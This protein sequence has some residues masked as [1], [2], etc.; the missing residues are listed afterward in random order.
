MI[1]DNFYR[2]CF[3]KTN[4]NCTLLNA[5]WVVSTDQ[6]YTSYILILS[7]IQHYHIKSTNEYYKKLIAKSYMIELIPLILYYFINIFIKSVHCMAVSRRSSDDK[8]PT[9]AVCMANFILQNKW[10]NI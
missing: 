9:S 3:S 1:S 10:K 2:G 5:L 4:A 8:L 7:F 6:F